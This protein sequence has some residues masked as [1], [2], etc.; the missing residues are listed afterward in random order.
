MDTL[1]PLLDESMIHLDGFTADVCFELNSYILLENLSLDEGKDPLIWA[2]AG[3]YISKENGSRSG[4][5]QCNPLEDA[6]ND[7]TIPTANIMQLGND[8][9]NVKLGSDLVLMIFGDDESNCYLNKK[10]DM[11]Q[12][13]GFTYDDCQIS[14][15]GL[16]IRV[17]YTN[18]RPIENSVETCYVIIQE[19]T[20]KDLSGNES[21]QVE[22]SFTINP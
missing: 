16:T 17:V 10:K 21:R 22:L 2:D 5:V 20:F 13:R 1:D 15:M 11:L 18:V 12:S 9:H 19:G 8:P 3:A 7:S 14:V 4:E 6:T